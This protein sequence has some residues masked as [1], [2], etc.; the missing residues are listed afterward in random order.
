M[1]ELTNGELIKKIYEKTIVLEEKVNYLSESFK[2]NNA[3]LENDIADHEK[4]LRFIEK[5]IWVAIGIIL[6]IS[7]FFQLLK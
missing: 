2:Q 4:R 7:Q 1:A 6:I 5:Y 3:K